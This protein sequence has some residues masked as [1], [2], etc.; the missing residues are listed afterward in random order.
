MTGHGMT[1]H[2][3]TGSSI[4]HRIIRHR[5]IMK[6]QAYDPQGAWPNRVVDA[7]FHDGRKHHGQL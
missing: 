4:R 1:G 5:H 2:G 3:M 7:V 6:Y